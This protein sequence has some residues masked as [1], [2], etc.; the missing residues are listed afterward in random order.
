MDFEETVCDF[1]NARHIS[2]CNVMFKSSVG[3]RPRHGSVIL[4]AKI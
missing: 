2:L 4:V 1:H 3:Q